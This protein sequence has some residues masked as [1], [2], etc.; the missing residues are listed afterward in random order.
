MLGPEDV[1]SVT[2]EFLIWLQYNST[3]ASASFKFLAPPRVVQ[4]VVPHGI[5]LLG[6]MNKFPLA[7][8]N[9][10]MIDGAPRQPEK[11]QISRRQIF[12]INVISRSRLL[13]G[14]PGQ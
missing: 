8:I 1:F 11:N 6:C 5:V 9:T 10:H 13:A 12:T 7:D 14:H 4:I 3:D 2:G